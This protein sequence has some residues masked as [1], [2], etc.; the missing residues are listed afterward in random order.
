R[1]TEAQMRVALM[2]QDLLWLERVDYQR[3]DDVIRNWTMELSA[4]RS[5]T[6][7]RR[8]RQLIADAIKR[9]GLFRP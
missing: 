3:S 2:D 6:H 4:L 9:L 8:D 5:R 7:D 1:Y